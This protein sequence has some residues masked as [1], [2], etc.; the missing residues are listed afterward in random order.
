MPFK[1]GPGLGGHCLP[2][3]PL[4]L[5]WKMRG[6]DYETRFIDLA[7]KINSAMPLHVVEKVADVLNEDGKALKGARVL[8]LGAAYKADVDDVRES[9][10]LHIIELLRRKG[11]DAAYNDPHVPT[12]QLEVGGDLVSV[13]LTDMELQNADC[14]VIVTGHSAYEWQ[15]VATEARVVV[16]TR[17]AL[18]TFDGPAK[19]VRL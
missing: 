4:Y 16:D 2:I 17:N 3:D 6:M 11:V 9:P 15:Q 19:I 14:V 13:E 10:A 8:V 18:K 1:P 7:D 5:S 12:L